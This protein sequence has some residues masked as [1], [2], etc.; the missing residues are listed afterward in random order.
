MKRPA[1]LVVCLLASA[2]F[3]AGEQKEPGPPAPASPPSFALLMAEHHAAMLEIQKLRAEL[4]VFKRTAIPSEEAGHRIAAMRME[5]LKQ[6]HARD[7]EIETLKTRIL[8]LEKHETPFF[9]ASAAK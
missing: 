8:R 2:V 9:Q 3:A 4:A 5:F 6:L 1:F 7:A